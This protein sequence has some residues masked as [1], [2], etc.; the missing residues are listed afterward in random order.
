MRYH[1]HWSYVDGELL[2]ERRQSWQQPRIAPE[3][4]QEFR[5]YASRV[6]AADQQIVVVSPGGR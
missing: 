2:V 5:E 1:L 4:Y 6:D 3:E